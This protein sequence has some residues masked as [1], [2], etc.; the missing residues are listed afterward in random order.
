MFSIAII[1][2]L[3]FYDSL[4]RLMSTFNSFLTQNQSC[5]IQFQPE[6]NDY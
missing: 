6:I 1:L 3:S 4:M 2:F 5:F